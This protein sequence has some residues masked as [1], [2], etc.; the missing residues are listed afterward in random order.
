MM[1]VI[2]AARVPPMVP[3]PT[4]YRELDFTTQSGSEYLCQR[5]ERV[6]RALGYTD[7]RVWTERSSY[8]DSKRDKARFDVRT[9]LI[10]GLPPSLV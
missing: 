3:K 8:Q 4:E 1:K 10:N 2:K 9:N 5:I 6:W 7:V